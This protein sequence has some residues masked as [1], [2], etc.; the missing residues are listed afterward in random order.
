MACNDGALG[1]F[2]GCQPGDRVTVWLS[3][4]S[5]AYFRSGERTVT[6]IDTLEKHQVDVTETQLTAAAPLMY[7]F[8]TGEVFDVI[9][10]FDADPTAGKSCEVHGKVTSGDGSTV[11]REWCTTIESGPSTDVAIFTVK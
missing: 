7:I 1:I 2:V 8:Q 3:N 4:A 10:R 6:K 5:S 9:L 11:R